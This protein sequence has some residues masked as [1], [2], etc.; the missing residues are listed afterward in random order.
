MECIW[1]GEDFDRD[2][3]ERHE[4]RCWNRQDDGSGIDLGNEAPE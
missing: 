1:C 4:D 3:L 2:E